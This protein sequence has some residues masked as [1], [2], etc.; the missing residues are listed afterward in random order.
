MTSQTIRALDW[1]TFV[2]PDARG[3]Y[4]PRFHFADYDSS[5]PPIGGRGAGRSDVTVCTF[6]IRTY[7]YHG[8]VLMRRLLNTSLTAVAV[9][10][11]SGLRTPALSQDVL[12]AGSTFVYPVL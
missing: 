1:G 9:L 5:F 2:W 11:S 7:E 12:G 10:C 4:E 3:S 8:D 6:T